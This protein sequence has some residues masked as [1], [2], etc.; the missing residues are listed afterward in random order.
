MS[1]FQPVITP[2]AQAKADAEWG[3]VPGNVRKHVAEILT[4]MDAVTERFTMPKEDT[5]EA[6]KTSLAII[7]ARKRRPLTQREISEHY[8]DYRRAIE[9]WT[10]MLTALTCF[11]PRP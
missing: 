4:A 9:P 11:Y 6:A 10:K 7:E 3:H 5:F 1:M 2:E 8:E